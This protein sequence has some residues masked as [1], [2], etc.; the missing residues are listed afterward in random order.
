L[1]VAGDNIV[2]TS[3]DSEKPGIAEMRVRHDED[4]IRLAWQLAKRIG[5]PKGVG[6]STSCGARRWPVREHNA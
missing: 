2:L 5:N 6:C 1:F 3:S 4:A